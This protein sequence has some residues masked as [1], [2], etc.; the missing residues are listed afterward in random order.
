MRFLNKHVRSSLALT[1]GLLVCAFTAQAQHTIYGI[2]MN[3]GFLQY[4]TPYTLNDHDSI[5]FEEL[6]FYILR[7]DG[8]QEQSNYAR[9]DEFYFRDPGIYLYRPNY[10]RN[11][12]FSNEESN[13]CFARSQQS[14]HFV[15]FW[16]R[17]FGSDPT[18]APSPY[19][20]DPADLLARA[21]R[22]YDV[23]TGQLGF[24]NPETSTTL[25]TYKIILLVHYQTE[26]RATGSGV[27]N[28]AGTLDVNP[29]AANSIITT[30]HEIGHTFQYIVSCDLGTDHG[31]RYGFGPN[32]SGGCA[33]WESC[34]QWQAF[35]VYPSRQFT[36]S[37][38]SFIYRY[39]HLNLLHE[40]MRYYN[41]YVQD[42]WCQ[43]HGEDF[44]GRLWRESVKPEDPVETYQR[45]TGTSQEDFCRDMYDYACRA[46][47][48][49]IDALREAGR[50]RTNQFTTSLHSGGGGFWEVDSA[51]CPQNYGFNVIRL[52]VPVAG[53]TVQAQ[54]QGE[55]GADGFR[56]INID[57]AGWRYGFVALLSDG[58]RIYDEMHAEVEGTATFTIPEN[59]SNL[60]FVI[61]GAPTEHWR[62]PWDMGIDASGADQHTA[63]SL[64]NDEQWPYRVKFTGT[65]VLK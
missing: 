51:N 3:D 27:D 5:R 56:A 9:A 46:I 43:L 12:D 52:R 37:W 53:T 32:A 60:W 50:Q 13:Y 26:W 55:A 65:A 54:F 36:D 2:R 28:K 21:E 15:V 31:W 6:R 58:T 62:H 18:Q 61:L 57:K 59:T 48:W 40:E 35:K 11:N 42:Y 38:A 64:A 49:D 33:W 7:A 1:A 10:L 24:G 19:T 16:E 39:S 34:A 23:Y 25:S 14:E 8:T 29:D 17:G 47:T 30:A 45:I 63:A 44:I 4:K 22:V 20:F 41:F